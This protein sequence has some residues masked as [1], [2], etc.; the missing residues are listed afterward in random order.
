MYKKSILHINGMIYHKTTELSL[1]KTISSQNLGIIQA[2]LHA[3]NTKFQ[4]KK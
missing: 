1:T 3:L 4:N 2:V